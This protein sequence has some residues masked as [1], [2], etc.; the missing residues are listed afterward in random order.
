MKLVLCVWED[1]SDADAG[2]WVPREG[3]P[4]VEPVIFHQV[5]FVVELTADHLLLTHAVSKEQTAIRSRIPAGMVRRLVT[6]TEGEPL[7]IPKRKRAK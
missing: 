1:A 3:A 4:A 5:G 2:P 7:K 6:L